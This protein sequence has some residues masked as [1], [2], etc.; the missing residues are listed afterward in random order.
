[1]NGFLPHLKGD[2]RLNTRVV[3]VSP[4][5]RTVTLADATTIEYDFLIST[6]PLPALVRVMGNEAPADVRAAADGLRHVSVRCVNIG[7]GRENLTEK[8]WIYYPEE[9][10]FHRIFVQGNASPHCNPPGGFGLTCEITY[11]EA[12]PL[13]CEGD[14]LIRRCIQDCH[15]VGFFTPDDPIWAANQVDMPVA[16]VVYDHDRARNVAHIRE[17]L[18]G[19]DIVLAGRYAE[20]EYYNSDHAFIAGKKAAKQVD[21]LRG[22][23]QFVSPSAA[24]ALR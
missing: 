8:H 9:P 21:E 7:V 19:Q 24:I 12:K 3:A 1:M 10:V 6:M 23:R 5:R 18:S 22:Q 11:S 14:E 4:S 2:L 13:P 17:W 16:Y 20:W 15:R